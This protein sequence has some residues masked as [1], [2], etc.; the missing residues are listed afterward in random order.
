MLGFREKKDPVSALN[1]LTVYLES[2]YFTHGDTG[3]CGPY[4]DKV[5]MHLHH[6][7]EQCIMPRRVRLGRLIKQVTLEPLS[8]VK[9]KG[10]ATGKDI[11]GIWRL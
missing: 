5:I 2:R 10:R 11:L 7:K 4:L 9:C 3:R 1:E 8:R 6:R